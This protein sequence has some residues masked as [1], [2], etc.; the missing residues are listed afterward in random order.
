MA[1]RVL[2]IEDDDNHRIVYSTMLE[3][4]GYDV[5]QAIDGRL[6][7]ETALAEKPELILLDVG[8]PGLSGWGLCKILRSQPE[9]S[10]VKVIGLTASAFPED[11]ERAG[12]L[13]MDGFMPKP[14]EPREVLAE[15][16]RV[17]GGPE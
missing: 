3:Y 9:T 12:A 11:H 8:L 1:K 13:C 15:V 6:G 7:L 10:D 16:E 14:A 4:A 17:I 2:I 5:L